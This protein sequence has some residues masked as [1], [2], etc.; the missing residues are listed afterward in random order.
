M[1]GV[2]R[3]S[4][5]HTREVAQDPANTT[6]C[7]N[8]SK[9]IVEGKPPIDTEEAAKAA[10]EAALGNQAVVNMF[11][12]TINQPM[13]SYSGTAT[14]SSFDHNRGVRNNNEI[15]TLKTGIQNNIPSSFPF[16]SN[17]NS[18]PNNNITIMNSV[19]AAQT[20]GNA[21]EL[22]GINRTLMVGHHLSQDPQ[23]I[24]SN[25]NVTGNHADNIQQFTPQAVVQ[26]VPVKSTPKPSVLLKK[27][28]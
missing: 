26:T 16:Q 2:S 12:G 21:I 9:P 5:L 23:F 24:A 28:G 4:F 17:H 6:F 14:M 3:A 15:G 13:N 27:F 20:H 18:I 7:V 25:V 8:V 10:V 19:Q 1:I 11:K 22:P